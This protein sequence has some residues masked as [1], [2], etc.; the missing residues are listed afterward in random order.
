MRVY[1]SESPSL[2]H[3]PLLGI[4][5]FVFYICVS[6][7]ALQISSWLINVDIWQKPTQYCKA[8]IL[9]L[10]IIFLIKKVNLFYLEKC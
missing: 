7:S 5:T 1:Q 8:I 2:S 10:N 6:F 3:H 9:Q 4:H